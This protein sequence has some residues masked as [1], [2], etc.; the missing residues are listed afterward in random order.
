M[1]GWAAAGYKSV[2][3]VNLITD[4]IAREGQTKVEICLSWLEDLDSYEIWEGLIGA[5]P[6]E[7]C[8]RLRIQ[9]LIGGL[10][11]R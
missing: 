3:L 7:G 6:V 9:T 1:E 4:R 11:E 5:I 10:P 2:Q 8:Q